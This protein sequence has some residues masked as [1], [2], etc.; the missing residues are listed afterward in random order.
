MADEIDV[1]R[2]SHLCLTSTQAFT[3]SQYKT[4]YFY[5]FCSRQRS[6]QARTDTSGPYT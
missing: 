3:A 5:I 6:N 4:T 1:D 2:S